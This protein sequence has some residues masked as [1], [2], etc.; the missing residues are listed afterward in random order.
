MLFFLEKTF[1]ESQF[2]KGTGHY[3]I[4]D[5][6]G[7]TYIGRRKN[8]VAR[9]ARHYNIEFVGTSKLYQRLGEEGF[10]KFRWLQVTESPNYLRDF[11]LSH[12]NQKRVLDDVSKNVLNNFTKYELDLREQA[13]IYYVKPALNSDY[14]IHFTQ[15][16]NPVGLDYPNSRPIS[17]I[18]LESGNVYDFHSI[19]SAQDTLNIDMRIIHQKINYLDYPTYSPILNEPVSF[20]DKNIEIKEGSPFVLNKPLYPGIPFSDLP[21][22]VLYIFNEKLEVI[23]KFDFVKEAAEKTGISKWSI[24]YHLNKQFI[25][26]PGD[27]NNEWVLFA[28]NTEV[29]R[30]YWVQVIVIDTFKNFAYSFPTV[31]VALVG[32]HFPKKYGKA[33]ITS[34]L[35]NKNKLFIERFLFF[36][37]DDYKGSLTPIKP[38]G[39]IISKEEYQNL[40]KTNSIP[41]VLVNIQTNYAILFPKV[42]A[43]LRY[44]NKD[45]NNTGSIKP[46]MNAAKVYIGKYYLYYAKDFKGTIN[47]K[48]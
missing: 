29:P 18:G 3:V 27:K 47:E 48:K 7:K 13:L 23:D 16:W 19:S 26:F 10:S 32:I 46:Y 28:R 34:D 25:H 30:T 8:F 12:P 33:R 31:T 37:R 4:F 9:W 35:V 45:P 21:H 38:T 2:H 42:G 20:I 1:T 11:I 44:F 6:S 24:Q 36:R 5:E 39:P 40:P 15:N 17:A 41:V 22:G 43:L 14:N